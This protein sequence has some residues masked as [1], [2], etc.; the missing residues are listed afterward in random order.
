[1][2][3]P[4]KPQIQTSYTAVQQAQGNGLLPGQ[5]LDVDF[6][7]LK[8][9]VS[10]LNDFVRGVTRSDGRLANASVS[11]ETLGADILLGFEPPQVWETGRN[12]AP[13]QTVFED[14]VFYLCAIPHTAGASFSADL[15]AGR[16]QPI[17][18]FGALADAAAASRD[19]A[20]AAQLGAETARDQAVAARNTLLQVDFATEAQARAGTVSDRIMS[21]LRATQHLRSN[22]VKPVGQ[23]GGVPTGG[24]VQS[25]G[26]TNSYFLRLADG[27]QICSGFAGSN[28]SGAAF[29]NAFAATFTSVSSVV[30]TPSDD[31]ATPRMVQVSDTANNGFRSQSYLV[32]F[33]SSSVDRSLVTMRYVAVG[34]WF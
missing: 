1:M 26:S 25:G 10:E 34:R 27:T 9:T 21:P 17:A 31:T 3:Y 8:A 4:Q 6:A 33:G 30:L 14:A 22:T 16:W 18:D 28:T 23:S 19:A 32:S 2:S 13:P 7:N 24:I 5:Q 11:R 20:V 12:Y 15:A 29:F